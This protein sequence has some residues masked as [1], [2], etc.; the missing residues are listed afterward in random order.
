MQHI[1]MPDHLYQQAKLRA[2]QA[3]LSVDAY[4]AEIVGTDVAQYDSFFTPHII[5]EIAQADAQTIVHTQNEVDAHFRQ[6]SETW[7]EHP[8]H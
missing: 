4:I 2:S 5:S 8:A 3:G 7:R 1:Q 6:K